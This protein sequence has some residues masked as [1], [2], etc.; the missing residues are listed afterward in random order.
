M[1]KTALISLLLAPL[2][3]ATQTSP[4]DSKLP[5]VDQLI[6]NHDKNEDGKL[7][8]DEVTGTQFE[9]QFPRWDTNN[10]RSVTDREIIA[11]R[12]RFGIA[13]DGSQIK[14]PSPEFVIP[15]IDDLPLMGPNTRLSQYAAENSAYILR[16]EPHAVKGDGYLVLTDHTA[17]AYL[18]PLRRLVS[19]HDGKLIIVEDLAVLHNQKR[20][21]KELRD[22]LRN[23]KFKYV[24]IAPR[25]E[26]FRENMVLGM[27]E[28]LSTIDR[29]R[30]IDTFP[31]FLVASN[32]EDFATLIEQSI[33]FGSINSKEMKP[34]AISQVQ[35]ASETRSLQKAGMLRK[36]FARY[37]VNTPVIAIYNRRAE[38]A[39]RFSGK[40]IW[41]LTA[42]GNKKFVEKF[43]EHIT[44]A[45]EQ[46]NLIVMHGHGIPGMS[47]SVDINGLPDN[48]HGKI[49]MSGSCFSAA[50]TKSD[51]PQMREAPG[52]YDIE[53]RDA[54][55]LRA[56]DNGAIVAFG[57]QRLSFGFPHLYPVLQ[58]WLNGQ[59]VGESYQQLLNGLIQVSRT[60]SGKFVIGKPSTKPPQN[61]LLYVVIGDPALRPF[62]DL[63]ILE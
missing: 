43:P 2:I 50:P 44:R 19:H 48:L 33:S 45:L 18:D 22:R 24:A 7:T 8:L 26:S 34:L 35:N 61:L 39:P 38:D 29:D 53:Q 42:P 21:F 46:A 5:S 30:E 4:A 11:F 12:K 37:G 3:A 52:G 20:E 49:L 25:L 51:L 56:V 6:E 27:W 54:F 36:Q 15:D 58:G 23:E 32:A 14:K 55:V 31:G 40:A 60:S 10:N 59:T 47:C 17:S 41:N 63:E 28:L 9:R 62:K 16:T 57:H 13:A 1:K